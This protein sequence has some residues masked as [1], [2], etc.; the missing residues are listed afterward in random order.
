M[1]EIEGGNEGGSVDVIWYKEMEC[2]CMCEHKGNSHA[3]AISE[4]APPLSYG[5]ALIWLYEFQWLDVAVPRQS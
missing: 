2:T 3:H 4:L 5:L 1:R